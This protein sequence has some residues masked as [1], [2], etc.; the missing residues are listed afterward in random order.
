MQRNKGD[1]ET[2]VGSFQSIG[3]W[4]FLAAAFTGIA[5]ILP[6]DGWTDVHRHPGQ[7]TVVEAVRIALGENHEIKAMKSLAAAQTEEIGIARSHLL[8]KISFEGR[9]LRTNNPGYAFMSKLNQQRIEAQDFNPDLLN[10]PDAVNDFQSTVAIEQPIFMK[11][12]LVGLEMSRIESQAREEELKRKE[13]EIAFQVVQ[14]CL[15]V[16]RAKEYERVS[17]V[18]VADAE[19][20]LRVARLRYQN[21][22]GQYADTLRARTALSEARQRQNAAR[23]NV[24]LARRALGLLLATGDSP[25]VGDALPELTVKDLSFYGQTAQRRG[26]LQALAFRAEI[27]GQGVRAAE[28]GYFPY[29]GVGGAY[30]FNDH[31]DPLRPEGKSWQVTA[32]LRWE[33]FDGA[34][35]G[36]ERSKARHLESRSREFLSAMQQGVSYRIYEAYLNVEEAGKNMEL[37]RETLATAEEGGRLLRLR[38][39]NELAPLGEL[40][41]AQTV[42]EQARAGLVDRSTD[43]RLALFALSFESGTILRDLGIEPN[44]R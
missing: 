42:V 7:M 24:S 16:L 23:K 12:A 39:E 38:Y 13:E 40:L 26:D 4:I 18:G 33:L 11:K 27:A 3:R 1:A 34:R 35:R 43:Y 29:I 25:D 19:E 20:H 32:F 17:G 15:N 22:V 21:D 9:Y 14:A 6:F 31:N 30:Q 36:Y 2:M 8:P 41:N 10:H 5:L 37:A 28:A 44:I